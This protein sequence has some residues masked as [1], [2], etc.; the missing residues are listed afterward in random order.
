MGNFKKTIKIAYLIPIISVLILAGCSRPAKNVSGDVKTI[1]LGVITT[2]SGDAAAY[3]EQ[4]QKAIDYYLPKINARYED[5]KIRFEVTYE[6]GKCSGNDA[7]SAYQ[8]LKDIDGVRF[9]IGGGCSTETLGI[10]PLSKSG[11]VLVTSPISSN[12]NIEGASPYLFSFAYSDNAVGKKAA[13]LMSRYKTVA[14]ISEQNDYNVGVQKAWLEAIKKYPET[15]VVADET[16]A[17]GGAD[18]RNV[19]EKVRKADPEA[20]LLNPNAGVTAK[21]LLKQLAEIKDWNDYQLFGQFSYM[22]PEALAAASTKSEGMIIVDSPGINNPE[23]LSLKKE[24]ENSK[25]T[26]SDLGDY[27]VAATIDN[28]NVVTGLIAELG[29]DQKAV[30]QA[31]VS[32]EFKGYANENIS[33]KNSSFA[34]IGG[35]EYI[36]KEGVAEMK[37]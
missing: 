36:V 16:F 21:N 22:S 6:D 29:D 30:R 19:L 17:K 24:I 33:F 23:F 8:K 34:G 26:L 7:V 10:A 31:L 12:P 37:K 9:I 20:I 27:L 25:G 11:E 28:L 18:F 13:E 4:E 1:K 3:G 32:R 35:V 15:A 14:I 2:L 5:K